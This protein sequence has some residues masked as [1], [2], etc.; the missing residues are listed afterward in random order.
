[1][2]DARNCLQV[3]IDGFDVIVGHEAVGRPRHDLENITVQ[4]RH[5]GP[6]D[7]ALSARRRAGWMGFVKIMASPQD[8]LKFFKRVAAF[9][10]ARLR[11]VLDCG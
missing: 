1:V 4:R 7:A 11:R 6:E 3:F 2:R 10:V 9:G 5:R 8:R